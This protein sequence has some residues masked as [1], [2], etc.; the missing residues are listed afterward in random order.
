MAVKGM[1]TYPGVGALGW[2]FVSPLAPLQMHAGGSVIKQVI[3]GRLKKR[4]QVCAN[5]KMK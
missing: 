1:N 2:G 5:S 4:R 3:S